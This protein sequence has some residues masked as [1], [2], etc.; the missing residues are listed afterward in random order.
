MSRRT[1]GTR[2]ICERCDLEIE[3]HG[4]RE[5]RCRGNNTTCADG[6]KHV[7]QKRGQ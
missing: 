1:Y 2:D 4:N 5:W 3:F 6:R 7:P